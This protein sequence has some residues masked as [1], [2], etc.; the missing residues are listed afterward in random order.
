MQI[1][2]SMVFKDKNNF[3]TL[4]KIS[5]LKMCNGTGTSD[6]SNFC[7]EA[8]FDFNNYSWHNYAEK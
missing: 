1:F 8:A 3:L 7:C 6:F 4:N 2:Y 5:R